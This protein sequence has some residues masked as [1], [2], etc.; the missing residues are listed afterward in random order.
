MRGDVYANVYN[1]MSALPIAA[2]Y[3]VANVALATHIYHGAWSMFQTLGINNP[4]YN[5]A[6][7]RFA[8]GLAAVILLGNLSFPLAVQAELIDLEGHTPGQYNLEYGE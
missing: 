5:N 7:R 8:Q 4:R 6:R 1:S 3:I 2:I